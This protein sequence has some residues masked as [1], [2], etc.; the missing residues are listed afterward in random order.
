MVFF[1]L[2]NSDWVYIT[3]KGYMI[4]LRHTTEMQMLYIPKMER[5]AAGNVEMK[6]FSTINQSGFSFTAVD[7]ETSLLY[8]KV[9]IELDADVQPG[10]YEYSFSDEVGELSTGVLVI[11]D[12]ESPIEY[13]KETEY[14]QYEE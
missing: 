6:A 12:L 14:E 7:E 5:S 2:Q 4:Y 11:G 3:K 13:I 9:L 8:H 10:E 1:V